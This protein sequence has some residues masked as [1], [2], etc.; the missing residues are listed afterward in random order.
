MKRLVL[1]S[2]YD[3]VGIIDDY[4]FYLLEKLHMISSELFVILNMQVNESTKSKLLMHADRVICR[5]NY[6]FDAGAYRDAI[7]KNIGYKCIKEYDEIVLCNDTFWGPLVSF[8][9]MIQKMSDV[10]CD[11][12]GIN[13]VDI[14]LFG[15]IQAY[16]MV[17]RKSI[18]SSGFLFNY[19]NEE[20]DSHTNDIQKVIGTFEAR[21]TRKIKD[22]G[23]VVGSLLQVNNLDIYRCQIELMYKFGFPIIKKKVFNNE[24][25]PNIGQMKKILEI[26]NNN[27]DYDVNL[28]LQTVKRKNL[29]LYEKSDHINEEN[30]Y[31]K[32]PTLTER[33]LISF[34]ADADRIYIYGNGLWAKRLYWTYL[35]NEEKFAGFIISDEFWK[36]ENS[37]YDDKPIIKKSDYAKDGKIIIAV[38]KQNMGSIDIDIMM[39]SELSIF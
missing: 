32:S 1:F 38:S 36:E 9:Y 6:G 30:I 12:W 31:Y 2:V 24:Y 22:A 7:V 27:Y 14:N 25:N 39:D 17:F 29:L 4:V 37:Y 20:I 8:E 10:S 35:R 26:I 3:D 34:I 11:C 15:H 33:E 18:I 13:Y 21:F 5:E 19:F 16:F 23:Y 28:I